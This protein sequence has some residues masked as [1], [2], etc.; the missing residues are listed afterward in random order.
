MKVYFEDG[1]LLSTTV[2]SCD[3]DI[4]IDAGMGVSKCIAALDAALLMNSDCV[5]YTNAIVALNNKYVWD[6]KENIPQLYIRNG[7]YQLFT[8]ITECTN[9]QLRESHNLMKM[10][11]A[12]EFN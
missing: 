6:E 1:N 4:I 2:L 11:L 12:G 10:Y 5:V 3:P 7:E 9:R 8:N